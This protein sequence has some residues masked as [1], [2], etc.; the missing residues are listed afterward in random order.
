MNQAYLRPP[1]PLYRVAAFLTLP[2]FLW[3]AYHVTVSRLGPLQTLYWSDYVRT[4]VPPIEMP[5]IGQSV[6]PKREY[7]VLL[8]TG[9]VGRE[10]PVVVNGKPMPADVRLAAV[11]MSS[12]QYNPWLRA[13]IY[14]GRVA[15]GFLAPPVMLSMVLVA[16]LAGGGYRLDQKRHLKFRE[17][18]VSVRKAGRSAF[19]LS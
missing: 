19:F 4:T 13:N 12:D 8:C 17:F 18:P 5:T 7:Q 3:L 6:K 16:L 15:I 2:L 9:P 1:L 14:G 11:P 10:I